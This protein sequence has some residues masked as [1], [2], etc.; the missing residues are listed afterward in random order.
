MTIW[1]NHSATQYPD[2]FHAEVNGKNAA[3][4]VN[5]QAWL[6]TTSCRPCRSAARR[7]SRPAVV[8][9]ASAADA[10]ID[11]TRDWL[12]GSAEGDWLSMAVPSDGSYGDRRGHH[13][14]VPVT[15]KDGDT[16]S[17]RA[18]R[19]TTSPGRRSTPASRSSSKSA[20]R[21]RSLGLVE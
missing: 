20:T 13:L 7:S 10:T 5:D 11:H 9:A 6:E 18:W 19:S 17:S 21:S 15:T 3:E 14:V 8:P 12:R 1:G 4:V 2:L 16:R